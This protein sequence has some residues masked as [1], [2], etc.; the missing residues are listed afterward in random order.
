MEVLQAVDPWAQNRV[1]VVEIGV[2]DIPVEPGRF[3]VPPVV[4]DIARPLRPEAE[5]AQPERPRSNEGFGPL[6]ALTRSSAAPKR[7]RFAA[8]SGG[9]LGWVE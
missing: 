5:I 4:A 2:I 7:S 9:V 1:V 6:A 8:D 3:I